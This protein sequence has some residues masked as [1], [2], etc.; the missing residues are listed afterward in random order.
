[1]TVLV[2]LNAWPIC[3]VLK[4]IR[5]WISKRLASSKSLR[6]LVRLVMVGGWLV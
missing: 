1:M 4:M 3:S 2:L 6:K 5:I